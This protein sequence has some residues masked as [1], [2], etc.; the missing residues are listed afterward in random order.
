MPSPMIFTP[1]LA[2]ASATETAFN[3][4]SLIAIGI[5]VVSGVVVISLWALAARKL[6][7]MAREGAHRRHGQG[8]RIG[9]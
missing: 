1:Q 2:A 6:Q 9:T 7:R 4:T 5:V 8:K 3:P